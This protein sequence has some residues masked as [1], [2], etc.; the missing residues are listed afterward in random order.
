MAFDIASF[1][2]GVIVGLLAAILLPVRER[3]LAFRRATQ[4]RARAVKRFATRS[5]DA[6]YRQD[7]ERD[8]QT[9]H[10]AGHLIPLTEI[11]VEPRFLPPPLLPDPTLSD[12]RG[13]ILDVVP[14]HHD[15]PFGYAPFNLETVT[16]EELA[17]GGRR[18]AIL[19]M[20]GAGK[21]TALAAIALSAL[22][23]LE[24]ESLEEIAEAV[25][26]AV[27]EGMNEEEAEKIRQRR[28]EIEERALE[29]LRQLQIAEER[30]AAEAGIEKV[31]WHTYTPMLIHLADVPMDPEVVGLRVDPAELLVRALQRRVGQV[32]QRTIPRFVYRRV[33]AGRALILIDG[34]D[35]LSSEL[36]EKKLAWLRRFVEMYPDNLIYATG[37]AEGYGPLL[38]LDFMPVF[39]RPWTDQDI[40]SLVEKWASAWPVIG[41]SSRR[42]LAVVPDER[43][44]QR[45]AANTRARAPMDLTLKVWAAFAG[46]EPEPGRLGWYSAYMKR[47]L[48]PEL[49]EAERSAIE[50]T[51]AHVLDD[52][53]FNVT[54]EALQTI[55]T[56]R[57]K[58]ADGKSTLNIEGLIHTLTGASRLMATYP[59][60]T[61]AFRH[62]PI[63]SYLAAEHIAKDQTRDPADLLGLPAW[64]EAFPFLAARTSMDR[65][66]VAMLSAPPNLLVSNLFEVARWLP[67][68]PESARWRG[69]AFKRLSRALMAPMQFPAVRERAMAALI[70]SRDPNTLFVFRQALRTE[71]AQVRRLACLGLGALGTTEAIKDLASMLEDEAREVQLAAALALGAISSERAMEIMVQ[72]LVSGEED[73]RR[74][75]AEALAAIPGEGHSIIR[76]AAEDK[77]MMLR[78]AAVFGLRRIKAAWALV[79]LYRLM[80]EDSQW[81]VRSAAEEA[82]GQA[83]DPQATGLKR[84]P[85]TDQM[86]WLLGWAAGRGEGVPPGDPANQVLIRALQQGEPEFRRA[87][88]DTLGKIGYVPALKPL[89]IALRDR[90]PSVRDSMFRALAGLQARL[91]APLPAVS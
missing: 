68:A 29:R 6:R 28:K 19:G 8:C 54:R 41:R 4:E 52:N 51:A 64:R 61:L 15:L 17:A 36:R 58:G 90:E 45:S 76:D 24:F 27:K 82:F 30:E 32:T 3:V 5:A 23:K 14:Q 42:K 13:S 55:L 46:D 63:C 79:A 59:G 84:Y 87:A 80:L 62:L 10:L 86:G 78:R 22:G 43:T 1:I 70:A 57:F 77:D 16:L 72:A 35:D 65:A 21:T 49:S 91:G 37:P 75:A 73:L 2:V 31:D 74:A 11:I 69:E 60:D 26:A 38:D 20:P 7:L 83:R 34:Y 89:Y 39:L 56:E 85:P 53:G 71:D 40:R 48:A 33:A 66:V 12:E 81:Y 88:A 25:D 67:D 18:L 50:V 47:Q 44:I 9:M